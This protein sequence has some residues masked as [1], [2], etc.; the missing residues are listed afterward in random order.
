MNGRANVSCLSTDPVPHTFGQKPGR[1]PRSPG[2]AA[3]GRVGAGGS[4]GPCRCAAGWWREATR[5]PAAQSLNPCPTSLPRV[6]PHPVPPPQSLTPTLCPHPM[7]LPRVPPGSCSPTPSPNL[8]PVSTPHVPAPCTP[9]QSLNPCPVSAPCIH[10]L[11]PHPVS[12]PCVPST[13]VP[14]PQSLTPAPHP[15][16]MSLPCVPALRVDGRFCGPLAVPALPSGRSPTCTMCDTR[17]HV[18]SELLPYKKIKKREKRPF[19]SSSAGVR[20][21][22]PPRAVCVTSARV[23]ADTF[24]PFCLPEESL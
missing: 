23:T 20:A 12:L 21:A 17:Y 9:L 7:S 10:S 5:G 16:P 18:C 19:I 4:Q 22:P 1:D 2:E 6:P 8:C 24:S 15:H 14:P 3:S 11:R 13:S